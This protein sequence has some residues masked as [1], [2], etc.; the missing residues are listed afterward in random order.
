[1]VT[2]NFKRGLLLKKKTALFYHVYKNLIKKKSQKS[3]W[4]L[5]MNM[6][7]SGNQPV[8]TLANLC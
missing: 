6:I 7:D 5:N 1:M 8:L 3:V 4:N 2:F